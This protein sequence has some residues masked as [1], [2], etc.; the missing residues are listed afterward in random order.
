[1]SNEHHA[2]TNPSGEPAAS[3]EL[4][5]P[6]AW[7]IVL[8]LGIC[9]LAAGVVTNLAFSLLG[10]MLAIAGVRGWVLDLSPGRAHVEEPLVEPA[11][12]ASP[13]VATP[14]KIEY[15]RPGMSGHRMQL[16]EKVHPYRA[17]VL[18]GLAGGVAMAVIALAYGA[19]SGRGIWYPINLAAAMAIPGFDLG[20][21]AEL[22]Q[23]SQTRLLLATFIHL[24]LSLFVGLIYGMLL[25]MLPS[26]PVLWGGLIA[27]LIWTGALHAALGVLNP[28]MEELVSWPWFIGSQFA[29]GIV[30]GLVVV[31]SEKVYTSKLWSADAP[32]DPLH[33]HKP[34]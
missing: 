12:R 27:P 19:I 5:A 22:E 30:A 17:G 9:L 23:F 15:L 11:R 26:R 20:T 16:P 33:P 8:A 10:L 34:H 3:F 31:R 21:L 32:V 28:A 24:M 14:H 1:M 25:P 18:G 13:I 2:N 6:T 4:P 7:P 29:F